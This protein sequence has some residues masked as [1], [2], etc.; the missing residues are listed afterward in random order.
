MAKGKKDPNAPKRP[1][2]SYMLFC[3]DER[4]NVKAENPDIKATEILKELGK[5]WSEAS[6]SDKE[7]YTEMANEAK[8][9]YKIDLQEYKDNKESSDEDSEDEPKKTKGKRKAKAKKDPNA[10]KKPL[11]P[12]F[13]FSG[14][15]R[16]D[17]KEENPDM[18]ASEVAKE[19][20]TRWNDLADDEKKTYQDEYKEAIEQWK[21]DMAE[22]KPAKKAKKE[23]SSDD[24]SEDEE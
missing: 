20:G 14:K 5:K 8:E 2:S 18:K 24:E 1:L 12:F 21:E 6:D 15:V 22:Y 7:K 19:I 17:V 13:A 3:K 4:E 16:G 10:P 11:T 23:E 9:Q